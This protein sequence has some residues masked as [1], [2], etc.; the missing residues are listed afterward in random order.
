MKRRRLVAG[1][2]VSGVAAGG[3]FSVSA[4]GQGP[5]DGAPEDFTVTTTI[6]ERNLFAVDNGR[7]GPSRGD[8]FGGTGRITGDKSGRFEFHCTLITRTTVLCD[9]ASRF[10][11]GVIYRTARIAGPTETLQI[12]ITGGTGAYGGA[13]GVIVSE[14]QG[15]MRS[16]G[17][18]TDAY[19]FSP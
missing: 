16:P 10:R 7:R 17:T 4:V 12:A 2:L 8:V 13:R 19:R 3:A 15:G 18:T 6:R 9:G 11:D 1:L 14:A 5:S